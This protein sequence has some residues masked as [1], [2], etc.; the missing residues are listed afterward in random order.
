MEVRKLAYIVKEDIKPPYYGKLG[1][2]VRFFFFN[3]KPFINVYADGDSFILDQRHI[4]FYKDPRAGNRD[5]FR[6]VKNENS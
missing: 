5:F 4:D 3:T 2:E 1:D 6:L